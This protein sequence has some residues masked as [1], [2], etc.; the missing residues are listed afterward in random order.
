[1]FV[2]L[3]DSMLPCERQDLKTLSIV[4]T[5]YF[6]MNTLINSS[7]LLQSFFQWDLAGSDCWWQ[8]SCEQKSWINSVGQKGHWQAAW[9][10][11]SPF[12]WNIIYFTIQSTWVFLK[13]MIV[14]RV[15]NRK[16][17]WNIV[18]KRISHHVAYY[19]VSRL[20]FCLCGL[21]LKPSDTK[22]SILFNLYV[23]LMM[24]QHLRERKPHQ[25]KTNKSELRQYIL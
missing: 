1:M 2:F 3:P 8:L 11:L 24:E 21:F 25:R 20:Y 17:Y 18:E 7:R 14:W 23:D 9:S 19:S 13:L 22:L 12:W 5:K 15:G 16:E 4:E 10:V 6:V